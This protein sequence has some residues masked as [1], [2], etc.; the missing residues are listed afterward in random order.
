L[1]PRDGAASNKRG[2]I[3]LFDAARLRLRTKAEV[4]GAKGMFLSHRVFGAI[5]AIEN[6]FAEKRKPDLAMAA[7]VILAGMI[8]EEKVIAFEIDAD[9]KIFA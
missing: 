7:D 3:V 6:Q 8:D 5:Q 2:A 9:V 1:S 4:R